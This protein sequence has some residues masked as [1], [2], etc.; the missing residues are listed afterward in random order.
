MSRI[1]KL[2]VWVWDFGGRR[3]VTSLYWK[4]W[5]THPVLDTNSNLAR[6]IRFFTYAAYCCIVIVVCLAVATARY[7]NAATRAPNDAR[8]PKYWCDIALCSSL[9]SP[10]NMSRQNALTYIR[11]C[12]C[13]MYL[14]VTWYVAPN[15]TRLFNSA[16]R[17]LSPERA[18]EIRFIS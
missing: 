18:N 11:V 2:R 8:L 7:K 4:H 6:N 12:D 15:N 5:G 13:C 16:R 1:W 9:F 17:S 14:C 3:S 10:I